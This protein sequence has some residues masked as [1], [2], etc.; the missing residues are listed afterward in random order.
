M[1]ILI[2]GAGDLATGIAATLFR[3]GFQIVMTEIQAPMTVR[4]KVAFSNAVYE[5]QSSVEGIEAVL[6]HDMTGIQK[7]W[8]NEKIPVIVD[9]MAEIKEE[10]KPDVVIDAIMAKRNL[11]TQMTDAQL[12]IGIGPGFTAGEDCH[13]VIETMRGETLGKVIKKGCALKNTGVPGNVGGYT[14]ERL[15]QAC[16]EGVFLP[17]I[18]IGDHV[19][20][21]QIVGYVGTKEIR[22]N[23]DGVIRG[24]LKAG[25]YVSKGM[26]LGDVDPRN[27]VSL[28]YKISD[29]AEKLGD[30][31][32][33]VIKE[34]RKEHIAVVILAAGNSSR[35]AGNKLLTLLDKKPVY[36]YALDAVC[37]TGQKEVILVS[38]YQDILD[39][40]DKKKICA[41][42]NP[43]P[44]KGISY[45]IQLG[46][47]ACRKQDPNVQGILFC[48]C[49]QP[50]ITAES[51]KKIVD[52]GAKENHRI[53]CASLNGKYRNPAYWDQ[54]F[55][56]DL[57][58]LKGDQGGRVLFDRYEKYIRGVAVDEQE[59][60]DL[61]TKEDFLLYEGD[62]LI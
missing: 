27:D 41:V 17:V 36:S 33:K 24:L 7:A 60:M 16:D 13:Y 15:L 3:N 20:K 10:F 38:Q 40:A 23:L 61:D 12:V 56:K 11:G 26:K 53:V 19:E 35:F 31:V 50:G 45:S 32:Q 46:I 2:K 42:H 51:I 30:S 9:E 47:E 49:D 8:D 54:V 44:D 21:G 25:L 62:Y 34:W 37:E 58:E 59:V 28:C 29:K 52:L 39:E 55:F 57:M 1:K 5:K 18:Q 14:I 6:V 22:S 48:V 43:F 4:R